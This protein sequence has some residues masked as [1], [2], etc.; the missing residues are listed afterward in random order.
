MRQAL[1]HTELGRARLQS[2][3]AAQTNMWASA[4]EVRWNRRS[5]PNLVP[6]LVVL[7]LL[8][9]FPATGQTATRTLSLSALQQS[10][11]AS[12]LSSLNRQLAKESREAAGEDD[13]SQFKHS[14]SVQLVARLTG[15]D[16]EHAY[17]VC[18]LLNFVV[19]G[20][21]IFWLM[22]KNLPGVFRDRTASIQKAM[23]EAQK[24]SQDAN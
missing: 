9:F 20:A 1:G 12:D 19:I 8:A 14:P 11:A 4:P 23:A 2:C 10:G 3:H 17:W 15:L 21:A 7:L 22:K 13:E 18:V 16:L 24:A 5:R 6:L